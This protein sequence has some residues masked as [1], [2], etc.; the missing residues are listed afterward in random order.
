MRP[1]KWNSAH[2]GQRVVGQEG[3]D[4]SRMPIGCTLDD[5]GGQRWSGRRGLSPPVPIAMSS[6]FTGSQM[7]G[8]TTIDQSSA[9]VAMLTAP[10]G[11]SKPAAQCHHPLTHGVGALGRHRPGR[12]LLRIGRCTRRDE[13][14]ACGSDLAQHGRDR[15]I[16]VRRFARGW[17]P[18]NGV[19]MRS[20]A[21]DGLYELHTSAK[22]FGNLE[23]VSGGSG[24]W[25]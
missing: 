24:R 25:P 23:A 20:G 7:Q 8:R 13:H 10:R 11:A 6:S 21:A 15:M 9:D 18:C 22:R 14:G 4:C 5:R 17:R 1:R 3:I 12:P 2:K 16:R 19:G